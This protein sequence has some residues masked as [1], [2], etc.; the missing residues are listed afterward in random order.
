MAGTFSGYTSST[1]TLTTNPT[2]VTSTGTIDVDSTIAYIPGILGSGG[3]AWTLTN[4]GTIKSLGTGGFGVDLAFGGLITNGASGAS[5]ALIDGANRGVYIR[6][7]SGTVTNFGT[8]GGTSGGGEGI[9]LDTGGAVFNQT[10]G[11]ITGVGGGAYVRG[12][13][14]TV[15]NAGIIRGIG[16]SFGD[17]GGVWL[18]DGGTVANTGTITSIANYGVGLSNIGGSVTNSGSI[19][20]LVGVGMGDFKNTSGR[21]SLTNQAGGRI[22]G[23]DGVVT[24]PSAS[25]VTNAGSIAG[26]AA[27][28]VMGYH[29]GDGVALADGGALTNQTGGVISGVYNGVHS[30]NRSA[31]I[32]NSGTIKGIGNSAIGVYLNAGGR[33]TNTGLITAPRDGVSL[34]GTTS[35]AATLSNAGTIAGSIGVSVGLADTG[36]NTV[37]NSGWI[38]GTGGTAVKFGAGNDTLILKPGAVFAGAVS[39]GG[40]TNTIIQGAAGTLKVTGFGGFE[41]IRLANGG[42]D[43][44]TLTSANF[45]GVG[46]HIIT[47]DDGNSRNTVPAS[48]LPSVDAIIVHAGT[49]SDTLQGG[50]GNDVFYAGGKTTMTGGAGANQ[51]A[52]AHIGTNVITDF[53]AGDELVLRKSGFNLGADESLATGTP[54]HLDASVFV[55]NSTG[56]FTT[57]SQ[58]FAYNT[59]TGA[60][61][62]SATGS[63]SAGSSIV[64]LT[65]HPGLNAG[66]SGNLFFTS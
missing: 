26:T 32:A 31:T 11:V 22:S 35:A 1:Y 61:A 13:P 34:G 18:Q 45:T 48:A 38:T 12:V 40:G 29:L 51:F 5:G 14:G 49:G 43:S 9:H 54:K 55:A 37:V 66:S 6:G 20:G 2:T 4:L 47:V 8:V 33:V 56:A 36:N 15:V 42:A 57:T 10:T 16:T 62:Y 63:G 52:F 30:T 44:L 7:G 39:G 58:R 41:T 59:T 23:K 50:A 24:T 64:V 21:V 27:V 46:G 17:G 60:L 53:G 19:T 28:T 65:G 3:V 25:T